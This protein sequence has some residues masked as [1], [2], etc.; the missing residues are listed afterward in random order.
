MRLAIALL[1][2][3]FLCAGTELSW[4]EILQHLRANVSQQLSRAANYACVESIDRSYFLTAT[5]RFPG[6]A[7]YGKLPKQW[8]KHD[9]LRLD[10]AV[11]EGHEI[12]S[13]HGGKS[14]SLK[15]IDDVVRSGPISSGSFV[16]YL[17]NIFFDAGVTIRFAGHTSS[18]DGDS[19]IFDYV[20]PRGSSRYQVSNGKKRWIVSYHGRF[21]GSGTN[22]ELTSLQ[23][24]ADE[25]P[26]ESG[27]CSAGSKIEYQLVNIAGKDSL[28]P[29]RYVLD[30]S[31]SDHVHTTSQSDYTQCREFRGESTL[32]FDVNDNV[33]VQQQTPVVRDEWLPAGTTLHVRL[34]TPV[35]DRT[36]FTG[37]PVEGLLINPVKVKGSDIV[38]PKDAVLYGIITKLEAYAEPFKHYLVS[39]RFQRLTFGPNSYLLDAFPRSL[40]ADR[41]WL[42]EAY[43]RQIPPDIVADLN[44]GVFVWTSSH[45]HKDQHFT[46]DWKTRAPAADSSE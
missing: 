46:A 25:V 23:L 1:L 18:T 32:S 27:I 5:A 15:G 21:T 44:R 20:V 38:I 10:V 11:S 28:I 29:K 26:S 42:Y 24:T 9:R 39:I 8:Y 45:F 7:D 13:W 36:S 17:R 6:C 16:G 22:Y 4:Q 43:S 12:F 33:I 30:M 40:D 35:D 3:P 14:F 37:D 19:Y 41:R 31:G 2:L 34:R